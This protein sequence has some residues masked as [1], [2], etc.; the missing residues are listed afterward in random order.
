MNWH[1]RFSS[2]D[3][4]NIVKH[5]TPEEAIEAA[6]HALDRGATVQ[7]IGTGDA[8]DFVGPDVIARIYEL[9]VRAKVPLGLGK[10]ETEPDAV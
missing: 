1:V 4:E 5:R 2:D 9:W 6:C 3:G 7:S 8:A 10:M